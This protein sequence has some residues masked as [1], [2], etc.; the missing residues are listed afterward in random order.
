MVFD[1]G[2]GVARASK[3]RWREMAARGGARLADEK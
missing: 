3:K 1:H 2:I